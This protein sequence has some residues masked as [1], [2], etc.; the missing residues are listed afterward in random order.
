MELDIYQY[1][2]FRQFLRDAFES[3]KKSHPEFTHRR[4]AE[5]ADVRNA[6]TLL[7]IIQ[8]K[9]TLSPKVLEACIRIFE[10][11]PIHAEFFR[12]LVDY[13][14]CKDPAEQTDLFREIQN[15]RA[16]SSFV[17]LN[18]AQVRYYEDTAYALVL[19]A[20]EAIHFK[21]NYESLAAFL[22]P[23]LPLVKVKKCVRDLCDWGLLRQSL[24]GNYSVVSRFIEPPPN[25][26]DPVRLMNRDWILQSAEALLKIPA[27]ERQMSTSILAVS[28][29]TRK[30]IHDRIEATR[31]E[32]FE[33]AQADTAAETVMQLSIQFYPKSHTRSKA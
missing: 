17:R 8:G 5:L 21:G 26:K 6:G 20:I 3:Y 11:K 1:D 23:P 18:S 27:K 33:L 7:Q 16:H 15:R 28:E 25:L 9:R 12:L 19:S 2:D 30:K 31:R 29:A 22:R 4:F 24:D 32:I 13:R 10:L 14:Q